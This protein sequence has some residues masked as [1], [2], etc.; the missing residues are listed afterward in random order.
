[1]LKHRARTSF[2]KL[3]LASLLIFLGAITIQR[4]AKP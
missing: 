2:M 4:C 3:F 1:M